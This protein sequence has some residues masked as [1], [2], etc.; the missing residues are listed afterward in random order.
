MKKIISI[1]T[2]TA[3][4]ACATPPKMDTIP[5]IDGSM[6]PTINS[7]KLSPKAMMVDVTNTRAINKVAQNSGAVA[8]AIQ[9]T[10]RTVADRSGLPNG[11]TTNIWRVELQDCPEAPKAENISE[12][13]YRDTVCLKIKSYFSTS[14]FVYDSSASATNYTQRGKSTWTR[15]GDVNEAYT[16]VLTALINGINQKIAE[17]PAA[18]TPTKTSTK[19]KAEK[20]K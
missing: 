17:A 16:N 5:T 1:F 11:K 4:A 2:L 13:E 14:G 8:G 6:L 20:K 19:A 12:N 10:L 3:L 15:T 18:A 7:E 9:E